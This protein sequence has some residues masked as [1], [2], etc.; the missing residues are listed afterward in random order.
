MPQKGEGWLRRKKYAEGEVWLFCYNVPRPGSRPAEHSNVIGLVKDFPLRADAEREAKRKEFWKLLDPTLSIS[1]T[2]GE[3]AQH[4]RTN[5]LKRNGPLSKRGGETV[6]NHESLL[7][8]YILPRWADERALEM[9]VPVI[10]VWYET[11]AST[12]VGRTYADG[13]QPPSGYVPKPLEWTS[14]EKI[15]STMSLVFSHA[16]RHRLLLG[17]EDVNPFRSAKEAGGVRCI[18]VSDYEATVVTVEQMILILD[19]LNTETTQMEWMMALLHACTAV[20]PEEGFALKWSDI[21]WQNNLIHLNRAWSKGKPTD[22]KN[23]SALVPIAMDPVLARF[24]LEWRKDSPYAGEGDWIFPSLTLKGKVPRAAS[25]AAQ[26]YL[27]PAAVHAGVIEEGSK[28]RFGWHNLRHSLATFLAGRVDPAITMKILRHKRI[29][30][31]LEIYTHWSQEK[32]LG[33]QGLF[34][35]ELNVAKG[36]PQPRS[37]MATRPREKGSKR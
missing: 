14:I 9:T 29:S 7:D 16:L 11:L 4:F 18:T 23:S 36:K 20:R 31:T 32:Q 28:K 26:D 21:D 19:F 33:A 8:G 34:I 6:S 25:S 2:F 22:G 5:E 30:T 1:P 13:K 15:R 27:R 35:T 10:E 3:L 37:R 12:A 24:L 17:G